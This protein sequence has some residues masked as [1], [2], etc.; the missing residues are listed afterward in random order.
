MVTAGI[1]SGAGCW[2]KLTIMPPTLSYAAV[3]YCMSKCF[4]ASTDDGKD[5]CHK[6]VM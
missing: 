5:Q 3:L 2:L 1:G 6:N 4:R